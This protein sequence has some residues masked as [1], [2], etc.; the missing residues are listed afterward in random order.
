M[1]KFLLY[2]FVLGALASHAAAG[3][4]HDAVKDGDIEQVKL[5]IAQGEDAN[6]RDR[7]LGRGGVI[8]GQLVATARV[9]QTSERNRPAM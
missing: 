4:L 2:A 1:S 8:S 7:N 9:M 3:P 6:K 5:L